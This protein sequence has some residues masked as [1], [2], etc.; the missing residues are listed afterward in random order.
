MPVKLI[1]S[2]FDYQ[3]Q[4]T[5]DN[6]AAV[7]KFYQSMP[8]YKPT[9]LYS[10]NDLANKYG[11]QEINVK[12]E[13]ERFGLEAFKG[14]GGLYAMAKLL[15]QKAGLNTDTLTYDQLLSPAIKKIAAQTTFY[16]ATDGNHGRG[17]AW[18]AQQLGTQAIVNMPKGSQPVRAQH[19]RDLGAQCQITS[20]NYDDV[21]KYTSEK[22]AKDP[23]GILIQDMAWGSYR[24]IPA[25]ISAGYSIV[26]DEFLQQV[27]ATPTHIFLQA[28]VGQLASGMIN[29]LIDHLSTTALPTIT[30]VEPAT[31]ACYFLS[32]Q[33][34]DGNPHT[35]PGS[36]KTIMA[37][38]NC[39]TPSAISWPVIR[40][41]A[42]FY[43]TLTDDVAA[44]GMRQ[45]A[46]PVGN[47]HPIIS[48]ES[49][50][51][52]FAFVNEIL[53]N[54]THQDLRQALKLDDTARILVINTEGATD[55]VNYHKIINHNA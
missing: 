42:K 45:L 2:P 36:P 20:M 18:A 53:R 24:D 38:L 44:T 1:K 49:G 16:T 27:D 28:G 9:P 19:I 13:S 48:G 22:A 6:N 17:I 21:V 15:A 29:A 10:L 7:A 40:D 34:G 43:G 23:H 55:P 50:A 26:A 3:P 25:S 8:S 4:P 32:A 54:P 30:I 14:T 41:S 37:G 31:V 12:D 46:K 33:K 39:Q 47:D 51:A 5:N 52:A 35:V 11:V